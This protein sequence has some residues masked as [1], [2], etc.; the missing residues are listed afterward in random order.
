MINGSDVVVLL[1]MGSVVSPNYQAIGCQRDCNFEEASESID[2]SCKVSR[3]QRVD[4]GRLSG[5][6]SLDLL[7]SISRSDLA[8][9]KAANRNGEMIQLSR[10]E[11]GIEKARYTAKIDS[12]SENYPDY[13][14]SVVSLAVTIDGLYVSGLYTGPWV[15]GEGAI[16]GS[17]IA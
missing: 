6:I 9:L 7:F 5:S 8:A 16:G 4:Y 14:E 11:S 3:A 13:A 1:N 15:I 17:L 12:L 2:Y 10:Q